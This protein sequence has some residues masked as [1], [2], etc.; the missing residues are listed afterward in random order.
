MK[1]SCIQI[2]TGNGKGKTTA[3]LGLAI[4]ALGVGLNVAIIHFMKFDLEKG[5]RKLTQL[6]SNLT[7]ESFGTNKFV[8][9]NNPDEE[10]CEAARAAIG[11]A[12]KL[13][14][15]NEYDLLI[16]DELN[17][18]VDF[19][20]LKWKDVENFLKERPSGLEIIITGRNAPKKLLEIADLVT[21]MKEVKHYYKNGVKAREG[22]EY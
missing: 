1:K 18:A 5:E 2:Y 7:I 6:F 15:T 20:L 22:I 13:L 19:G 10:S 17:V 16:M 4:R 9:K 3:A 21:E 11:F 14:L 8:D 12:K